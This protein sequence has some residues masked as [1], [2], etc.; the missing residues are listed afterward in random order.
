MNEACATSARAMTQT[1][2]DHGGEEALLEEARF[3]HWF[4]QETIAFNRGYVEI[5]GNVVSALWLCFVLERMHDEVRSGRA[6]LVDEHYQFRLTSADCEAETGIT[7]A[8][9]AGCRAQ[10]EALGLLKV[11]GARG[12]VACYTVNLRRLREIMTEQSRPLLAALQQA[13]MHPVAA[14]NGR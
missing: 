7:R 2:G 14:G 9:Q 4:G 11:E 12:K 10:L 6:R 3:L 1:A 8:Q 5:T 13:R